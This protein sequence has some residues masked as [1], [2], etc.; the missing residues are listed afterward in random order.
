MSERILC[1]IYEGKRIAIAAAYA[2]TA[3]RLIHQIEHLTYGRMK[4]K[5]TYLSVVVGKNSGKRLC[6]DRPVLLYTNAFSSGH[7]IEEEIDATFLFM[8]TPSREGSR[9]SCD[10]LEQVQ[11]AGR[12]RNSKHLYFSVSASHLCRT[13]DTDNYPQTHRFNRETLRLFAYDNQLYDQD[14]G[15]ASHSVRQH[16][17]AMSLL[18][19]FG[20]SNHFD[21]THYSS[22]AVVYTPLGQNNLAVRDISEMLGANDAREYRR[23][24]AQFEISKESKKLFIGKEIHLHNHS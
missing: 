8:S 6:T 13:R 22:N 11:M 24:I 12:T 2:K 9:M 17:C 1:M 16:F 3:L 23:I 15:A 5:E 21:T 4:V 19:N 7:S 18:G 10:V 14:L 20:I